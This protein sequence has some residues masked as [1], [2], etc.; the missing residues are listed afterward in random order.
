MPPTLRDVAA[1]AGVSI[2]TVSNV[3]NGYAAVSDELRTRVQTALDELGYRP[4]LLARSLKQG[5]S[6][7][8]ALVLPE[9]DNPYFAELTRAI[10]EDGTARGFTVMIDQT[11]GDP[12]R[13]RDLVLRADRSALFDGLIVSPLGLTDEQL[14]EIPAS[15]A[16]VFLG[17]DD[18]PK[19]DHVRIDN[20]AAAQAA[21]AHLIAQGCRRICAVGVHPSISRGTTTT[22][23]EGYR[24]ALAAAGIPFDPAL[25]LPTAR[26]TRDEG[27]AAMHAAW[28]LS[29][30]PDGL[31]CFSDLLA[32]GALRAA[33]DLGVRVPEE[34]AIVGFDDIEDGRYSMPSLS[35]VSPD[36]RWIA[37]TAL[38]KLTERIDSGQTDAA[39][40]IAPW[41]LQVRES[42]QRSGG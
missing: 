2:R 8:I 13:E 30:P 29:E 5:R 38:D 40:V 14:R 26:F 16:V 4:N 7:L 9:L 32:L 1:A 19:F 10:V 35:T 36:K 31:F 3:V 25:V 6:N 24:A 37:Q 17:E 12:E 27:A 42:S 22:R 11:S 21:T 41:D 39:T 33:H 15:H 34:L 20:H 28:K 23:L 18:H